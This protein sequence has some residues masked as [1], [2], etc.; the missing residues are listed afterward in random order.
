[1]VQLTHC[2]CYMKQ[3]SYILVTSASKDITLNIAH[4]KLLHVKALV[5]EI[6][7]TSVHVHVIVT[8]WSALAL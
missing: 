8:S 7:Q 5:A 4:N 3:D 6:L 2:E 1:M